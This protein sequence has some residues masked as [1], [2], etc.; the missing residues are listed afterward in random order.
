MNL[1]RAQV[2]NLCSNVCSNVWWR[3]D[4]A[5]L[6]MNVAC[7]QGVCSAGVCINV[8]SNVGR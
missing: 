5:G 4:F 2:V 1:A 8:C 7:A 6:Y 3:G